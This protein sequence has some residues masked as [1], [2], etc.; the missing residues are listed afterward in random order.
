MGMMSA[1]PAVLVDGL[2]DLP[3][4]ESR[5]EIYDRPMGLRLLHLDPMTGAEHYLVRYP[6]GLQ[7]RQH[8]HSAARPSSS[9][10]AR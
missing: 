5:S 2:A 7:A 9:W 10:T 4:E 3:L 8:H 1:A 6:A